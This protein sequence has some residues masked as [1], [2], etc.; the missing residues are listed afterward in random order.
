MSAVVVDEWTRPRPQL[1]VAHSGAAPR[2]AP[3]R[4]AVPRA[5]PGRLRLTRR[6]IALI[7][8]FLVLAMTTSVVLVVARF[9]A[10]SDEP[11]G[12]SW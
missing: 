6:A 2:S 1:R 4:E 3:I 5:N 10:V 9:L 7:L 11:L 8:G 12:V